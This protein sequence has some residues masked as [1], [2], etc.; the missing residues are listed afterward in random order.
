MFGQF[1][2][3]IHESVV[4][5]ILFAVSITLH[6]LWIGHLFI[7]R[8]EIFRFWLTQG[9]R[10]EPIFPMLLGGTLLSIF[11]FVFALI[12]LRGKDCRSLTEKTC[13]FF[14][15]SLL[16]YLVMTFPFIYGF[17]LISPV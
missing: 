2:P 9:D 15:I 4:V 13:W 6:A 16:T 7:I 3:R 5:S 1:K 11:L 14:L 8:S 17:E 12:F 10:I